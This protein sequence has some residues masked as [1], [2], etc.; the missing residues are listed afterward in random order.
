M[1]IKRMV[2]KVG[3]S[4]LTHENGKLDLV[5]IEKLV[6][7]VS[8]ISNRGIEVILVSSGAIGVGVSSLHLSAKPKDIPGKQ[9][10]AAVGQCRLM[11]IYERY[12]SEYGYSVGQVLLSGDI[13]ERTEGTINVRNTFDRL[14][15]FGVIPIVNENDTVSTEEIQIGDN[16]TLSAI[17]AILSH[18]D[19]LVLLSDID[20]LYDH[21]PHKGNAT[22]IPQVN[23]VTSE[24]RKMATGSSTTLGTGGMVTKLNAA[25]LVNDKGIAMLLTNG[26]YPERIYEFLDGKQPGTLFNAPQ[27]EI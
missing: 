26:A 2:I 1:N 17:V 8:D 23:G 5:H 14:I 4:T 10:A 7:L 18:S 27:E 19:L 12:F 20:G 21:D 24:I 15:G 3:T 9:A 6:R 25:K 11:N 13:L 22:L 16:D